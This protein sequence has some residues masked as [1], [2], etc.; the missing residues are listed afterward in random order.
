MSDNLNKI[1]DDILHRLY[2]NACKINILDPNQEIEDEDDVDWIQAEENLLN[3]INRR[4]INN[5]TSTRTYI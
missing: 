4:N 5:A 3:E 2:I 1:S